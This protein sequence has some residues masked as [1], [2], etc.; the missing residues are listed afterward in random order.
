[1]QYARKV[2]SSVKGGV[3]LEL[4]PKTV[5]VGPNGSGKTATVQ[6][7]EL[8]TCGWAS[9][10]EGRRRVKVNGA[11]A[12]LF[13]EGRPMWSKVEM[14]NGSTFS[15]E[16]EYGK[17]GAYKTPIHFAP[18]AVKWPVQDFIAL[19]SGDDAAVRTWLE[20]QVSRAVEENDILDRVAVSEREEVSRLIKMT[21]K[22]DFLE[23]AQAARD[24]ARKI[25]TGATKVEKTIAQMT[26]GVQTPLLASERQRMEARLTELRAARGMMRSDYD[27][28]VSQIEQIASSYAE[29]QEKL[30]GMEAVT[31][32]ELAGSDSVSSLLGLLEDHIE[33]FGTDTCMVCGRLGGGIIEGRYGA[34]SEARAE[35]APALSRRDE[36]DT[37][38]TLQLSRMH[39]LEQLAARCKAAVVIEDTQAEQTTLTNRLAVDA[40]A[41]RSWDNAAAVRERVASERRQADMLSSAA[42]SLEAAGREALAQ[43]KATF[44]EAV[45][46]FL[47]EGEILGVDVKSARLGL[48]RDGQLHSALSG[49]EWSR[50]LLALCSAQE[51]DGVATI[52]AP[53][54]RA[55]DPRTLTREMVALTDSPAQVIL[56]STVAPEAVP[57]GWTVVHL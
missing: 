5:L 4:G 35:L 31:D 22:M 40:A 33:L 39:E 51:V 14:S 26:V 45:S 54:D 53:E 21:R 12:R 37:L 17:D 1:M 10:M 46:H 38:Q 43:K 9:D 6:A 13:P 32:E 56:M 8:A 48:S 11:L 57:D 24:E 34:A 19:L 47:P 49:S 36:R 20:G 50:V 18:S 41:K 52:L 55:W 2:Q 28:L 15:W 25:R 23:L 29:D 44:E 3:D 16:M 30:D 42:K 27:A 7:I